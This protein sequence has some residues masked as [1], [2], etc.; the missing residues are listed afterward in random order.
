[1]ATRRACARVALAVMGLFLLSIS[2]LALGSR[3]SL[4]ATLIRP[5]N[6]GVVF[7]GCAVGFG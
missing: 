3:C 6:A 5:A 2:L 4:F 7:N 1:M